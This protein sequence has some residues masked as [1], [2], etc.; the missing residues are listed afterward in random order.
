MENCE[1][2]NRIRKNDCHDMKNTFCEAGISQSERSIRI[3]V[4]RKRLF[5]NTEEP[6]LAPDGGSSVV[7]ESLFWQ[8]KEAL[9]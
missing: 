8:A 3:T 9:L 6:L 7:R 2:E 5:C 4:M 1:T